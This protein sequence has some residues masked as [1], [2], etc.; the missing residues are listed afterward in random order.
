MSFAAPRMAT[1]PAPAR[2]SIALQGGHSGAHVFLH[3]DDRDTFVRKSA[4][5]PQD[6]ARLVRQ[7]IKQRL[8]A[9]QGFAFP[10]VRAIEFDAARRAYFDMDYVPSRTLGDLVRTLSP[11]D[12]FA[13]IDA[14]ADMLAVFHAT[15]Q[16]ALQPARFHDK[17][18]DVA[19]A[20]TPSSLGRRV[21]ERL[22]ASDWSSI[23]ASVSHGDLTFENILVSPD[24]EV[25]F[26]DCDEPFAS[27][28]QLDLG[29]LFQ[30]CAGHWCLRAQGRPSIGA[31]ERLAQ[32]GAAFRAF[33]GEMDPALPLRLDQFAALHLLRTVP[34]AKTQDIAAFALGAAARLLEIAS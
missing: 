24:G 23:P 13:A 21:V 19:K 9:A 3:A 25:S 33:A 15:S 20:M 26:I 11:F 28:W 17:I 10:A 5:L 8:F 18:D 16:D 4:S 34:Y 31:A 29:K 22:H 12:R 1:A 14:V 27:S 30:D 2:T 6:N 7:A 32:L